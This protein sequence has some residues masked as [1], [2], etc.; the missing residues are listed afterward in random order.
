MN[1]NFKNWI[2]DLFK[3]SS[4]KKLTT[5]DYLADSAFG[6]RSDDGQPLDVHIKYL[7]NNAEIFADLEVFDDVIND[8]ESSLEKLVTAM[9]QKLNNGGRFR[10]EKASVS[11]GFRF[12]QL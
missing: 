2:R 12:V 6:E 8:D 9:I 3:D 4:K 7:P 10:L 5:L 11:P 1:E